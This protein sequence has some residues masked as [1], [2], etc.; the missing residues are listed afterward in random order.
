ML[1][2]IFSH[3]ICYNNLCFKLYL[4]RLCWRYG[5][6]TVSSYLGDLSS[7][8]WWENLKMNVSK[9]AW[10]KTYFKLAPKNILRFKKKPQSL[11]IFINFLDRSSSVLNE[12]PPF[13]ALSQVRHFLSRWPW[14]PVAARNQVQP[15]TD[16]GSPEGLGQDPRLLI[17]HQ[18][19]DTQV[20]DWDLH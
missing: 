12:G 15:P 4:K 2:Q 10:F 11:L 5:I 17:C 8:P 7:N 3:L 20:S 14:L 16:P 18:M 13:E 19:Q 6:C 9:E 1:I